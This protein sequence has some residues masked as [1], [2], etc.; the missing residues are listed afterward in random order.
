MQYI[1]QWIE[2]KYFISSICLN[3]YPFKKIWTKK[4]DWKV[5]NFYLF[6]IF[7]MVSVFR[8]FNNNNTTICP[9]QIC[10]WPLY[11]RLEFCISLVF[12]KRIFRIVSQNLKDLHQR[13]VTRYDIK[14]IRFTYEEWIIQD[15]MVE[16]CRVPFHFS[17]KFAEVSHFC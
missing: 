11:L 8:Y 1:S 17:Y 15:W 9:F 12:I 13:N 4:S 7:V 5:I 10:L 14:V 3:I 16:T 6:R 2:L